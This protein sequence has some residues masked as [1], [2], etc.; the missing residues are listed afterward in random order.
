V[1]VG[2]AASE[3][4][5]GILQTERN[6]RELLA[7]TTA[8][9]RP[10]MELRLRTRRDQVRATERAVEAVDLLFETAG[11][12]SLQRGNVIE[13]AWRDVHAGSM[14][15]AN[16]VPRTLALYGRGAFGLPIEDHLI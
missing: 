16:E 14:H 2:R 3:I 6:L 8:G 15:V 12:T 1:A 10:P 13:R 9:E 7:H 11:G 4:D 5:A